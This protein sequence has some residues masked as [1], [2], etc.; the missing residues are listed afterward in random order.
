[1]IQGLCNRCLFDE[2]NEL[3]F[4]TDDNGCSPDDCTYNIV[5]QA[6]LQNN[7]TFRGLQLLQEMFARGFSIHRSTVI[8]VLKVVSDDGLDQSVKQQIL[9]G[10]HN[11]KWYDILGQLVFHV[12]NSVACSLG[13]FVSLVKDIFQLLVLFFYINAIFVC[14]NFH[15]IVSL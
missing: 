6:L 3:F 14:I 4:E 15:L 2:V 8:V 7:E 1:M 11:L 9:L 10:L 13:L 12:C 5:I